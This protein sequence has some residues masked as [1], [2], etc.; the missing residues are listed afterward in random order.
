MKEVFVYRVL[1]NGTG[2]ECRSLDAA[3]TLYNNLIG[4][5]ATP[6]T[7]VQLTGLTSR[8]A[9][10]GEIILASYSWTD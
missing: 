1:V 7:Y 4:T 9:E 3:M 5:G 10:D 2:F 8:T 6:G